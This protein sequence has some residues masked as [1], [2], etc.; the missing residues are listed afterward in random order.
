MGRTTPNSGQTASRIV[1][2][3]D[4]SDRAAWSPTNIVCPVLS[5]W[6]ASEEILAQFQLVSGI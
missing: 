2:V 3:C 5:P 1:D 6:P 4:E